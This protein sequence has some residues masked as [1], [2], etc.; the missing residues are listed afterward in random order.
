MTCLDKHKNSDV[1]LNS[2]R[3]IYMRLTYDE[4]EEISQVMDPVLLLLNHGLSLQILH[5]AITPNVQSLV[6]SSCPLFW[7]LLYS[8]NKNI[9]FICSW[10]QN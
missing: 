9:N 7:S 4:V 5:A 2:T 6:E 3:I 10:N 8:C 1:D